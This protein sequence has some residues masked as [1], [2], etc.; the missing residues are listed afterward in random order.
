[1]NIVD[2]ILTSKLT[3][4]TVLQDADSLADISQVKCG[5]VV[6]AHV[7]S[8]LSYTGRTQNSATQY[9]I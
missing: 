9:N 3:L 2:E 7:L 4:S 1:M 8:D 6:T 5:L